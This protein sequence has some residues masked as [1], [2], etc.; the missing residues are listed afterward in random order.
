[1][2]Y[3]AIGQPLKRRGR[4]SRSL[5]R[6][7]RSGPCLPFPRRDPACETRYA[8]S[9]TGAA[10]CG[11]VCPGHG[12]PEWQR[13]RRRGTRSGPRRSAARSSG[14]R[15]PSFAA[16]S[17]SAPNVCRTM[18]SRSRPPPRGPFCISADT[19]ERTASKNAQHACISVRSRSNASLDMA[20]LSISENAN[21][22]PQKSVEPVPG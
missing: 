19:R 1:M 9:D 12:T 17:C 2:G 8:E 7:W 13:N 21:E 4:F 5:T 10:R 16:K 11:P 18:R 14:G 22:M 6:G 20:C 15:T 3:G